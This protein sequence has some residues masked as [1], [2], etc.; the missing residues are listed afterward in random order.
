MA[1]QLDYDASVPISVRAPFSVQVGAEKNPPGTRFTDYKPKVVST[2]K[3]EDVVRRKEIMRAPVARYEQDYI[4]PADSE[5]KRKNEKA[6]I[7]E[8]AKAIYAEQKTRRSQYEAAQ[9]LLKG[10]DPKES[11]VEIDRARKII[12]R[13]APLS[14][15]EAL[16]K[17]ARQ[18]YGLRS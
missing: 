4:S 18:F 9:N 14:K 12:A 5:T 13:G 8:I 10:I 7:L 16:E 15:D 3:P 11:S 6:R 1:N 17:A 2:V